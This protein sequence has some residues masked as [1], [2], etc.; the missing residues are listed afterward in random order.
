MNLTPGTI[1]EIDFGLYKHPGVVTDRI[2][3]SMPMVI[4][5]SFRKKGVFEESWEEFSNGE[6]VDISGYPGH[7]SPDE[8]LSR[9]RS[10]LGT[11]WNLINW[12]CEHFVN[13]SH[14][15]KMRSPQLKTCAFY[16]VAIIGLAVFIKKGNSKIA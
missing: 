14:G 1:V 11:R 6:K 2:M 9:A 15:L 7:L 12:N 3:N 5:N 13:W 16:A 8:V 10:R 4:S